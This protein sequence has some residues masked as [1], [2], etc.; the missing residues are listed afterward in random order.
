MLENLLTRPNKDS[1]AEFFLRFQKLADNFDELWEKKSIAR[2]S[3]YEWL[4][5]QHIESDISKNIIHACSEL[6]ENCIKYSQEN[7][8]FFLLLKILDKGLLIESLNIS[9][10]NQ[11]QKLIDYLRQL[12]QES[13]S[14]PVL[15]SNRIKESV[16]IEASQLGIISIMIE[17]GSQFELVD[18]E[19][20]N[21]V[22][23]RLTI[24]EVNMR[25]LDLITG[26]LDIAF[27][28]TRYL[29]QSQAAL[30]KRLQ[31]VIANSPIIIF[32]FDN[33]GI[34]TLAQ[35]KILD[36]LGL[37]VESILDKSVF[38]YF[39]NMPLVLK[40]I[41]K[42]LQGNTF[43]STIELKGMIF[44]AHW[45]P[46]LDDT[47]AVNNVTVV[48]TDITKRI[49]VELERE[50]LIAEL[51]AKNIRLRELDK[52]KDEFLAVTSHELRT[53][54]NGII[55][56]TE[57][58]LEGAAGSLTD[59]MNNNLTMISASGRR[60]FSLVND[61]LDFSKLKNNDIQ[62]V[63]KPVDLRVICDLILTLCESLKGSKAINLVNNIDHD[64]FVY[65]D[66]NRLQQ[67]LL[68][69]VNNALKFT[70]TGQIEVFSKSYDENYLSVTVRDTGIGIKADQLEQI[71][72]SFKQ[73]DASLERKYGGFGLG[74]TITKKLI[75]LHSGAIFVESKPDQGTNFSFTL[76]K[77]KAVLNLENSLNLTVGESPVT[78]NDIK[79]VHDIV[80]SKEKGDQAE[81]EERYHYKWP[82]QENGL[83]QEQNIL[84]VD[85]DP[86]NL[87]VI[88]NYL[89]LSGFNV[90]KAVSGKE[91]LIILN[92]SKTIDLVLLDVM[93]PG[94]S[95][96]EVC[97]LIR[98]S[99]EPV[100]L[101]I[102]L[103]TAK[104]QE[105]DL[106]IGFAAGANDY[107]TKPFLKEELIARVQFHLKLSRYS[108]QLKK[109]MTE[110]QTLN[111]GLEQK[112]E[113]RTKKLKQTQSALIEA[114][115]KAGMAD[116]AT[117]ILHNVGNVLNSVFTS[118]FVINQTLDSSKISNFKKANDLIRDKLDDIDD[119][120][121]NDP[122]GKGL[123]RYYINLESSLDKEHVNISKELDRMGQMLQMINDIILT[124]QNYAGKKNFITEKVNL[125]QIVVDLIMTQMQFLEQHNIKIIKDFSLVPEIEVQKDKLFHIL[126]N[127]IKNAQEAMINTAE[128]NRIIQFKIFASHDNVCLSITDL[129]CGLEKQYLSKI[130]N[131]GFSLKNNGKGFSL[132][133]CANYMTEMNGTI[134]A[135]SEGEDKGSTFILRF[136]L[137]KNI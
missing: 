120:I 43:V 56:I 129:G 133:N 39:S 24:N 27:E 60:L 46:V 125:S 106:K 87:Q 17:T 76:P 6:I 123:M 93:M 91:A 52:L 41:I 104:T 89:G 99:Y 68:N 49:K 30:E 38:D 55:G 3:I 1:D 100:Q 116:I 32:S 14:L 7:E 15:Y 118:F 81:N 62:L 57:S 75:E 4:I 12:S 112:V 2:Q 96:Y 105:N 23:V 48:A 110:L 16:H 82:E 25:M 111:I 28:R 107:I 79:S 59:Q 132:H 34:F 80:R 84:V 108:I 37:K 40:D 63:L 26:Q 109:L 22:H 45:S 97:R 19:K 136:P 134:V 127:I 88:Y 33:K 117:N 131:H 64:L 121:L 71:F 70:D 8:E 47:S 83:E 67:I 54:L 74:L 78:L 85:D 124:Q 126:F 95:G 61:I 86:I 73:G 102:I 50:K 103:L 58:L 42:A 66:E 115:H 77:S 18:E 51:E 72:E 36:I 128:G 101:P 53:P 11:K 130:F 122:K 137:K 31:M 44:E 94:M 29:G 92:E 90:Q 5:K 20:E 119:F 114:A 13:V 10:H 65:A 135:E 113:E 9:T 35:G 21:V 98:Q 69:L